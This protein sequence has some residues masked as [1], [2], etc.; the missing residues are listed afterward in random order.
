[1]LLPG[2]CQSNGET[3]GPLKWPLQPD[4]G[5]SRR[6]DEPIPARV[7][8]LELAVDALDANLDARIEALEL[9][10]DALTADR[11]WLVGVVANLAVD[12]EAAG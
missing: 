6:F 8:S 1:M 5:T 7:E 2:D 4:N 10:V 11:A 9:A 3:S 12:L